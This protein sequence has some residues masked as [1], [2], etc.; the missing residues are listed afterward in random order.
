MV[1][2]SLLSMLALSL[3]QVAGQ[4]EGQGGLGHVIVPNQLL[5]P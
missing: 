2:Y 1:G 5:L 3:V 4:A